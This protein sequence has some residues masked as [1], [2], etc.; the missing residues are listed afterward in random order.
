MFSRSRPATAASSRA[1][2]P[3]DAAAEIQR[4]SDTVLAQTREI[5]ALRDQQ[6]A[7]LKALITLNGTVRTLTESAGDANE[8]H[9]TAMGVM[10]GIMRMMQQEFGY[11]DMGF[12]VKPPEHLA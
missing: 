3:P 8:H 6:S 10:L 2:L 11:E 1:S 4:L 9:Q 7:M 5:S 12:G